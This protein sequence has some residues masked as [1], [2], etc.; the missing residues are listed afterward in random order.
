M[1]FDEYHNFLFVSG[2]SKKGN[3]LSVANS[4]QKSKHIN[5]GS[6]SVDSQE[7]IDP[8]LPERSSM[9]VRVPTC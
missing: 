7:K 8:F 6:R 4:N 9:A 2:H 5:F 1:V 3:K